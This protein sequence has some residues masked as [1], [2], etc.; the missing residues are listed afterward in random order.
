M[1]PDNAPE[2]PPSL[3]ARWRSALPWFIAAG[4]AFYLIGIR[5]AQSLDERQHWPL[6][7]AEVVGSKIEW[8]P[9]MSDSYELSI[10]L[11]VHP[12][13]RPAFNAILTQS[14]PKGAL[15]KR[16]EQQFA[17]GNRIAVRENPDQ[18]RHLILKIDRSSWWLY[19]LASFVALLIAS[20][21]FTLL[22]RPKA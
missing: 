2:T 15:E 21:G 1:T 22:N 11:E 18:P 14:G 5:G 7:Q 4:I 9:H 20:S 10:Q 12:A 6:H 13:G 19:I 17:T 16:Q 8:A 3:L